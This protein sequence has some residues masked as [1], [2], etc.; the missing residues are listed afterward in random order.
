M[1]QRSDSYIVIDIVGVRR[2]DSDIVIYITGVKSQYLVLISKG[3]DMCWCLKVKRSDSDIV[4]DTSIR[5]VRIESDLNLSK[6]L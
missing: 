4:L 2:S 6:V 5:G 3:S 1:G